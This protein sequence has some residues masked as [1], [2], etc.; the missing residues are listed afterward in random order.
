MKAIARQRTLYLAGDIAAV[1]LGT[2]AFNIFRYWSIYSW[3]WDG[4]IRWNHDPHVAASY[5]AF[6][7]VFLIIS[8]IAGFYNDPLYKSRYECVANTT[9]SSFIGALM[10]Y[11]AT[12][13]DNDIH[14]RAL[15]YSILVALFF[16]YFIPVLS[17]R[18]AIGAILRLRIRKGLNSYNVLV[19][20]SAD[21]AN[22]FAKQLEKANARRGFRVMGLVCEDHPTT[23]VQWPVYSFDQLN[24]I[25]IQNDI[26]A[27]V[28]RSSR[29]NIKHSV[30]T[31]NSLFGYGLTILLPL[32]FYNL[33]TSR[34]KLSNVVGEPLV[35]ITA[36]GMSP[37]ASNIKRIFDIIFSAVAIILLVPVY[38]AIAIAIKTDSR[39]PV[40][41]KQDRVGLHRRKFKI[42]KFRSMIVNS[43]PD[44]PALSSSTDKRVTKIGHI[45]R[46][47]R[48]DELP[49]FI[50]VLKGDMSVVGP[51]PEREYYLSFLMAR[52]PSVCTIHKIRPG[53]TS[54]GTVKYGY[55]SDID[56][57]VKRLYYDLLYL[58]NMSLSMDLRIIFHT[59][60]TIITGK[61]V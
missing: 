13:V 29:D 23:S 36:P 11:F 35:D 25:V 39:G 30:D 9:T 17:F 19:V 34:P 26:K 6:P 48:L 53:L 8:A 2:L 57:M 16:S 49:Q 37:A 46:K 43:E 32:E 61:G 58:E 27:F 14:E 28:V 52:E 38:I 20:G 59:I 55:A 3:S 1:L 18:Y 41:Y 31:V 10:F 45:L 33:I 42:I 54:L 51:R 4:F 44:G 7:I 5:V 12:M 21:S 15:H 56:A 47:Y 24:D 60:N 50:N 40:F 22:K